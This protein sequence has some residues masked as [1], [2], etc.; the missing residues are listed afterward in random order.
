MQKPYE[1]KATVS[2][3]NDLK[4][5]RTGG[6]KSLPRI[7]GSDGEVDRASAFHFNDPGFKSRFGYKNFSSRFHHFCNF[8]IIRTLIW[9]KHFPI[10]SVKN[11]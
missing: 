9:L 4:I 1:E 3:I 7:K 8:G 5:C 6:F 11:N 10:S 2:T